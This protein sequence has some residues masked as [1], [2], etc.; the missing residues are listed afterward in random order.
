MKTARIAIA[1]LLAICLAALLAACGGDQGGAPT[2]GPSPTAT[3]ERPTV[4]P[5]L[6]ATAG[7]PAAAKI[8]FESDR[9]GNYEVYVM[10]A[11]GSGQ[12]NL[13]NNPAMDAS[14]TW[15]P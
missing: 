6:T 12:T 9:D 14:P 2:R 10:N 5:T 15:S 1:L 7:A 11:D 3:A 4:G 8:A 13:T